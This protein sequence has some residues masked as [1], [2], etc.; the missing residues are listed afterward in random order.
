MSPALKR[1]SPVEYL[2]LDRIAAIRSEYYFGEIIAMSG[3]TESHNLI[4]S[5]IN[6]QAGNALEQRPCRVYTS[7]MRVRTTTGVYTYPDVTIVCGK[8]QLEDERKDVLLNP[9]VIIEVLSPSTANYDRGAKFD[10]YRSIPSLQTYVIVAQDQ[11]A[12]DCYHRQPDNRGWLL[13]IARGLNAVIQIPA[14]NFELSLSR[15]Y[16]NV[17]FPAQEVPK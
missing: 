2:E 6:R 4:G 12:I 1:I 8:P 5:N 17:E 10:N 11:P 14:A 9:L 15:V 7:D 3:G 16:A 13:T